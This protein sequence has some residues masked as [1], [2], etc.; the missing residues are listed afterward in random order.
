MDRLKQGSIVWDS[1]PDQRGNVKTNPRP[2]VIITATGE[3]LLDQPVVGVAVSTRVSEPRSIDEVRL[4]YSRFGHP[5]TRLRRRCVAVCY[6]LVEV[7]PSDLG[8]VEGYVP[9]RI[10]LKILRRVRELNDD[11][12]TPS[13]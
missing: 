11:W 6:W 2:I 7:R 12:E 4:P 8:L 5:A 10:L 1:V 9:T 3:I 13:E